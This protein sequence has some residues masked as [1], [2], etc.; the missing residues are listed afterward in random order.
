MN[1]FE[2]KSKAKAS[3]KGKYGDA[4]ILMV[5]SFGITFGV[6]FVIGLLGLGENTTE[7]IINIVSI[8]ISGLF[9]FG[10][11]SYYLKISRN[12]PVTYK[13]LFNKTSM[14]LPY[15]VITFLTG[16]FTV[17]WGLLFIIP[18]IIAALSY[19]LVY[20]IKLDNPELSA[21]DAIAKSKQMMRGHKGEFCLLCLSFLG[22]I[23]LG[24]F[25]LGILYL[26]LEPYMQVTYANFYN[27][28]RENENK[29]TV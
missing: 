1:R 4:I 3:L 20:Y 18:G 24:V 21:M 13:E 16:L 19:S 8:V 15:L 2:I 29:T 17:L 6:G 27:S 10:T 7:L 11:L 9:G 5:I 26:W 28:L 25:T 14:F 23:I 22:W 12:E